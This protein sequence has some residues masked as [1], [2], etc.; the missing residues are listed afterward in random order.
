LKQFQSVQDRQSAIFQ[1]S[2]QVLQISITAASYLNI[3]VLA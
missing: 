3:A 1:P 2:N